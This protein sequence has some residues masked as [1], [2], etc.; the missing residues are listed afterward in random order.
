MTSCGN[1]ACTRGEERGKRPRLGAPQGGEGRGGRC[2]DMRSSKGPSGRQW[3][4]R[5]RWAADGQDRGTR[6]G[7]IWGHKHVSQPGKEKGKMGSAQ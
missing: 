4:T 7:L 6:W 1:A 3:P 2:T 5:W